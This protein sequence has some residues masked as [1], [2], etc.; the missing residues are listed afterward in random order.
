MKEIWAFLTLWWVFVPAAQAQFNAAALTPETLRYR[1]VSGSTEVGSATLTINRDHAA[2]LIHIVESIS[3]LF[4]QTATITLRDNTSL[5]TLTSHAVI[6]RDNQ[7]H[8][9]KLQYADGAQR[10][11]GE[12]RRPLQFGGDR[13][14]NTALPAGAA[15]IYAVAPLFRASSLAV[16]RMIQFPL[17]NAL[18]NE[19]GL[20][21]AW[22]ARLDSVTVP[23]GRY[24]CFRLEAYTGN[25]R[26]IL[27]IDTQFPHRIIRQIVP[28]LDVKFE[29]IAV[30]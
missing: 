4:E 9:F 14:V 19:T 30:E 11:T 5:H 8:Q 29:L 27:N 1:L 3:G 6:S 13:V 15:D 21:R 18:E 10:V 28:S 22:I 17:F 20:A 25:A 23:A 2:S 12:I 16:G 7:Y 26:L 24:E